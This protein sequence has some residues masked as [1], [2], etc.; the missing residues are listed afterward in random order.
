MR[1]T[2]F[3]MKKTLIFLGLLLSQLGL[4]AHARSMD[5]TSSTI[6]Q[7]ME[8]EMDRS[9]TQ[10]K[11]DIFDPPYFIKYQIRHNDHVEVVG[12]FGSLIDSDK[13]QERTLFVDVRLGD[14]QFD[15]STPGSHKY[16]V[17]HLLPLDDDVDA[18]KRALWYETDLRYKQAIMNYMKKKGRFVSGVEKH[19]LADFSKGHTPVVQ[20]SPAPEFNPNIREWEDVVRRTSALFKQAPEIEKSSVRIHA[21][22]SVRYYFDSEGN[23][24]RSDSSKYQ[25]LLEASTKAENGSPIHDQETLFFTQPESFPSEELLE[26]KVARLIQG[27]KK[28][29]KAPKAETYVGP[30]LFS[31]DAA[32]VL[33]HEAV[34]HRLEGDRLRIAT[35]GKTF[36]K[37]IGKRILPDFLT[38][39]DNPQIKQ[40]D[41]VDL[42]GHYL[43]DDEGQ[44][45]EKVV[46]VDQGVLKSFLLSRS[47]VLGMEKTNGHARSD[48]IKAP[49]S[50]M[51]NLIVRSTKKAS[52]EQLKQLLI[53]EVKK[54]KK[55][56]GLFVK[57]IKGGETQTEAANFQVFKGKPLYL[58]KVYPED[59]REE[60]VRGV[61]FVGTPLSMISKVIATGDDDRV[62][63]G[64]CGA[65]SGFLPVTSVT[66][67]F[68]LSEVELQLSHE[69]TLR[70]PILP[71][72]PL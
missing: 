19:A 30:A 23:K 25:L 41:G 27:I 32:A 39:L 13:S 11:I 43:F 70:Q 29:Q 54:R 59:G 66:P 52:S 6:F 20:I 10:L 33:I 22:R 17:K 71:P 62:I 28:L 44:K 31:P 18:L 12:S 57:K 64:L 16:Q 68:L 24:I 40:L 36:M 9:L 50:R 65:E 49:M 53:A 21:D 26:E 46:L 63:N 7:A 72:P 14:S 4:P 37:K 61:E 69:Q 8:E 67:S 45:G 58:Y 48:G 34:G 15:S 38:V 42:V 47:P 35:D 60:L 51:G 1:P 2:L 56:Y 5:A 55:P 3:N